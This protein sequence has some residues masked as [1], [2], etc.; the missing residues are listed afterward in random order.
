MTSTSVTLT[1]FNNYN[2]EPPNNG[3]HPSEGLM[4]Y[5][6]LTTKNATL[7]K[8]L[9]DQHQQLYVDS[10]GYVHTS[11]LTFCIPSKTQPFSPSALQLLK[12]GQ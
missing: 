11:H 4:F 3:T 2:A 10:Q 12:N 9:V 5:L 7:L 6:D 1:Y 8:N